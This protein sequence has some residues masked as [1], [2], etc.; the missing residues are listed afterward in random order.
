VSEVATNLQSELEN[1]GISLPSECDFEVK[2]W[3][4][5]SG[6]GEPDLLLRFSG[7]GT[8]SLLLIIEVKLYSGKSECGS[9]DQLKRYYDLLQDKAALGSLIADDPVTALI[10]LTERYA[11]DELR[12]SVT[13]SKQ[14]FASRR[15]FSLQWQDILESAEG[16]SPGENSLLGEV[17]GFL[18]SRG[19]ERFRG[20]SQIKE[21]SGKASG[22][23][24][25][26]QYFQQIKFKAT[27]I[28]SFYGD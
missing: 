25:S 2:F 5:Y 27:P 13:C 28:G 6:Y 10:Y 21:L 11:A 12:E 19:F 1:E 7:D 16:L 8:R 3:P 18:K 24:Y 9:N 14:P 23:F 17:A 15:M 26:S 22:H 4:S 20:F